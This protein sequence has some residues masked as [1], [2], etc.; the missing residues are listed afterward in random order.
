MKPE[1][2][3]FIFYF[4]LQQKIKNIKQQ[5]KNTEKR[6][7]FRLN[8]LLENI[9]IA[10]LTTLIVF[11]VV[12]YMNTGSLKIFSP[13]AL[14]ELSLAFGFLLILF[15]THRQISRLFN[16]GKLRIGPPIVKALLEML[17]VITVTLLLYYL[18]N[19][20]PLLLIFSAKALLP[21]RVRTAFIVSTIISLFFY[22]FVERERSRKKLQAQMLHSARL[23]KENYQAQL[24][25]LKDQVQPHFLFNSL[26]VLSS[27]ILKDQEQALEF[28]RRLSDLYRSFLDHGQESLIPLTKE[29]EVSRDY[30][31]LLKTRFGKAIQF[32]FDVPQENNEYHIPP[33]SL[34][35]LIENAVKHNGSTSKAPLRIRVYQEDELLIVRNNLQ[36]R[37]EK[38]NSTGTGLKN[39]KNRYKYLTDHKVLVKKTS[40]EFIVK[41]PLLK[42][43]EYENSNN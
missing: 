1:R 43:E 21:V 16:S 14:I 26:N 15:W 2:E 12:V 20:T 36:P 32:N 25:S 19:Y 42:V 39:I 4:Y 11:A 33:G 7:G 29:V 10:A 17:T 18:T 9:G 38:N 37:H 30:C 35:M 41:L 8:L 24:E 22:Y 3:V 31:F 28:T 27:L 23:Q 34:Q 13:G 6:K 40:E 5:L